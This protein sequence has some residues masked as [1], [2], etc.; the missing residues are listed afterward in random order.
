M[1]KSLD[2]AWQ[3]TSGFFE[4]QEKKCVIIEKAWRHF[5]VQNIHF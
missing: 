1:G 3:S 2:W 5:Q 4:G